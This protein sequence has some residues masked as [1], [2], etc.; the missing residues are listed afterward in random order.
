[1][2]HIDIAQFQKVLRENPKLPARK[3][4][5]QI[6]GGAMLLLLGGGYLIGAA[7]EK[8]RRRIR[9]CQ[10]FFAAFYKFIFASSISRAESRSAWAA[11]GGTDPIFGVL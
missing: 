5:R 6:A 10:V 3:L 2:T 11:T 9:G 1:M 8:L 4:R 7:V